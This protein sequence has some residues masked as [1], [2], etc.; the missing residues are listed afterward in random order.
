MV[1]EESLVVA[2]E[3]I[4]FVVDYSTRRRRQLSLSWWVIQPHE[5]VLCPVARS[6]LRGVD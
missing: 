5:S 4:V 1:L 3:F 6:H 2:V